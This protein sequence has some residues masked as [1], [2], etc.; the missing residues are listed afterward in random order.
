MRGRKTT[1]ASAKRQI[2]LAKR[3]SV[4]MRRAFARHYLAFGTK[5]Y[6]N[7]V[8]SAVAAGYSR[9]TA[10]GV[11]HRML[12]CPVVQ[13]EMRRI[14]ERRAL[15]STIAS[16]E[17]VLETVTLVLR[18]DPRTL[19]DGGRAVPPDALPRET[20]AA[21]AAFKLVRRATGGETCEYK[22]ADKLRAAELLAKH[23]GLFATDNLQRGMAEA[24]VKLVGLPTE[25]L[26]LDEWQRI[27]AKTLA[28]RGAA[29]VYRGAEERAA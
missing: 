24:A 10:Q 4:E 16:P 3:S 7:A 15:R 5:T 23:H 8:G 13:E 6:M 14:R 27:A 22:L 9:T 1:R 21:V 28:E 25:D 20:A 12:D 17:E 29:A 11:A 26:S 18:A 2:K 19:F